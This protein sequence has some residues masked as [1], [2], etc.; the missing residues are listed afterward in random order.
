MI[1]INERIKII[2][3]INSEKSPWNNELLLFELSKG[4]GKLIKSMIH[5]EGI[6]RYYLHLNGKS[7]FDLSC[8]KYYCPTCEKIIRYGYGLSEVDSN[9]LSNIKAGQSIKSLHESLA[10]ISPV[11]ELLE[12]G[13]YIISRFNL[14]PTDGI[15]N[16][17]WKTRSSETT[18]AATVTTVISDNVYDADPK[19]IL[20]TQNTNEL[21]M[22]TVEIYR[23]GI[24]AGS[25][26]TGLVYYFDGFLCAL[27]DGHHRATAAFLEGKEINALTLMDVH[28]LNTQSSTRA[29][30]G[31]C[32][33]DISNFKLP[34]YVLDRLYK[35][36]L[37]SS[38]YDNNRNTV[39]IDFDVSKYESLY[40]DYY[41]Y[42]KE[43]EFR[44]LSFN[45][46]SELWNETDDSSLEE[47]NIILGY[48]YR[49]KVIGLD[50]L[51]AKIARKNEFK[52]L[53]EG[54]FRYLSILDSDKTDELF[55]EYLIETPFDS[56]DPLRKIVDSYYMSK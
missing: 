41:T 18:N 13:L 45:R 14:Y 38:S 27:L 36:T 1:L 8:D 26:A 34:N 3:T 10:D 51:L 17:F 19:Y 23:S 37:I 12:D 32:E 25:M 50:D 22:E 52:S 21:N 46:I 6:S 54:V 39:Q 49:N 56:Y 20:P 16:Y 42:C 44:D 28:V 5:E 43:K 4:E 2:G 48:C 24:K 9:L 53:R 15:G 11:V 31:N 35:D 33:I 30:A 47:I 40:P 29:F 55:L 7:L